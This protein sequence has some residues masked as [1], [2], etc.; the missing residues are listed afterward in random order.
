MVENRQEILEEIESVYRRESRR[1]LATLLENCGI[2]T[3]PR[4]ALH[5]SVR[6]ALR[7]WRRDGILTILKCGACVHGSIQSD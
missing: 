4:R 5:Q 2:S 6:G 3:W 1:V 7:L